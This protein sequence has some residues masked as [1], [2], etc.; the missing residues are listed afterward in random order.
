MAAIPEG[1]NN[2]NNS[3][4]TAITKIGIENKF[5]KDGR[6]QDKEPNAY[7]IIAYY[8]NR[9]KEIDGKNYVLH[10]HDSNVYMDTVALTDNEE[11]EKN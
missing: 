2:K 4:W 5:Y 1:K 10:E 7:A 3:A 8:P 6:N 9:D 11:K